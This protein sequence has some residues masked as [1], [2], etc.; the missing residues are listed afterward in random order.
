MKVLWV[1]DVPDWAIG[2]LVRAKVYYN[3][4][5]NNKVLPVHPRDAEVRAQDFVNEVQKFNPD[6]IVYEYFRTAQQ[7]IEAFPNELK[8]IPS[9]LVH[10]NQRD[11]ALYHADWNELGIDMIVT[12]TQKCKRKLE[13]R[14]YTNVRVIN[15]GIDVNH[16]TFRD[17]DAKEPLIGYVGRI[18][19]WK[20]LKEIAQVG[21]ELGYGV[22]VM[23]K[24]DKADYWAQV[25]KE[26][27]RFD[28]FNCTDD[29]RIDAYH[30]MMVYVG[31]SEDDYEE[32]TLPYL[33]AMAC[34]VPVITTPN[35]VANDIAKDRYNALVVPFNDYDALKSAVKELIEDK[36]LR[37]TLRQNAW[38][39]VKNMTEEKMAWEYGQLIYE[40]VYGKD[41]LV[42]VVLPTTFE[43]KDQ[44]FEILR[45]LEKQTH[46]AIEV[47]VVWDENISEWSN[48]TLSDF[49]G[50]IETD[51]MNITIRH[52]FTNGKGYGLACA[53]NIGIIESNGRYIM[54]N[55]SRLLPQ[56]DAVQIFKQTL[57]G[58]PDN[59][60]VWLFGDK[61]G[62]K[63]SFVENFSFALRK[64]I[65]DFGMFC[66]RIDEYGGMSQEVRTRWINQ[67]GN[68]LYQS[69]A[70]ATEI[71][72]SGLSAEKRQGIV[73]MKTRL[74]KMYKGE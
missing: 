34:G 5:F 69:S 43:R 33:E 35:G 24:M 32:G 68:F 17:G 28:F 60:K 50:K 12:H 13:E 70:Q 74:L 37:D 22:Q 42:S 56:E 64:S 47:M 71:T 48:E 51:S 31:N 20:G 54:F 26:S 45:A 36:G 6:I 38:N 4:Q 1:P 15:H 57:D 21:K 53:R 8:K 55:D 58:L 18:V 44:I 40:L 67:G 7:L 39:T 30:S 19:P 73:R 9:I 46:K 59:K 14:G 23:G 63:S 52:L 29:E 16:F 27:L 72:R 65:I 41:N 62:N 3:P 66:E 49:I 10:H 11:K 2:H 25:S 61:G